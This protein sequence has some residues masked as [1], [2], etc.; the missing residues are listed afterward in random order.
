MFFKA[1][2]TP[3]IGKFIC[4]N[5]FTRVIVSPPLKTE[6]KN[7]IFKFTSN[8]ANEI[9]K[10]FHIYKHYKSESDISNYLLQNQNLLIS[11]LKTK[12]LKQELINNTKCSTLTSVLIE[13][14]LLDQYWPNIDI[15]EKF[16]VKINPV[17]SP[18]MNTKSK[19]ILK[20]FINSINTSYPQNYI[21][22]IDNK[23]SFYAL[24]NVVERVD[25][26]DHIVISEFLVRQMQLSSFTRV[27]IKPVTSSD[28]SIRKIEKIILR[29]S[30][31]DVKKP[32]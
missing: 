25:I 11:N 16:I 29:T 10:D 20:R 14:S 8:Q 22:T 26:S 13:K 23:K 18:M 3:E 30:F 15:K 9:N 12:I 24:L 5:N 19:D 2:Y 6:S 7:E 1:S 28:F 31:T 4:I 17:D 27:Q 21:Q 32:V